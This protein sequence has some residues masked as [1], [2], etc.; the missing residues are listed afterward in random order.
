MDYKRFNKY[1][2]QKPPVAAYAIGFGLIVI[3]A[4]IVIISGRFIPCAQLLC[5]RSACHY[6]SAYR[7]NNKRNHYTGQRGRQTAFRT[8]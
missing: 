2:A 5:R 3:G 1:F 8:A 7:R 6:R 4:V